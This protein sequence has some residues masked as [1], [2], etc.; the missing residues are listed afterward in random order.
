MRSRHLQHPGELREGTGPWWPDQRVRTGSLKPQVN[1][2][3]RVLEPDRAGVLR[4]DALTRTDEVSASA[5][6]AATLRRVS[7]TTWCGFL[8]T[9]TRWISEPRRRRAHAEYTSNV[10]RSSSS[11][12]NSF[13]ERLPSLNATAVA[14]ACTMEMN[15]DTDRRIVTPSQSMRKVVSAI[16]ASGDEAASVSATVRRPRA[17][18]ASNARTVSAVYL[19]IEIATK[20]SS[21]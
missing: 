17:L 19:W 20:T 4:Y 16:R 12:S 5:G 15:A 8:A 1:A 6:P 9:V 3:G 2:D 10:R 14:R 18:A 21:G 7:P 13:L 11:L